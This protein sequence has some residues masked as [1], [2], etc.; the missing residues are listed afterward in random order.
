MAETKSY[1]MVH[2]LKI[3]L[4]GK[5]TFYGAWGDEEKPNR[6]GMPDM[7]GRQPILAVGPED[8]LRLSGCHLE[9]EIAGRVIDEV[10][11]SC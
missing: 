4:R 2:K 11:K 10:L 6:G 1:G 9:K 7:S 3:E 8:E 5:A